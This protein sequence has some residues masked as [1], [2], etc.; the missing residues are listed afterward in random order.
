MRTVVL[1][2]F[3]LC[4]LLA[5]VY[6]E[7]QAQEVAPA[8]RAD[9]NQADAQQAGELK[10]DVQQADAQQAEE[11][12]VDTLTAEELSIQNA[13]SES[14][15]NR[16]QNFKSLSPAEQ[17]KIRQAK[18]VT[19]K[20]LPP[21]NKLIAI[22]GQLIPAT[23][24]KKNVK[25]IVKVE[26]VNKQAATNAKKSKKLEKK[27]QEQQ[28]KVTNLK[29]RIEKLKSS[30]SKSKKT[31]RKIKHLNK[32]LR[33]A[34]KKLRKCQK[35]QKKAAKKVASQK[36]FLINNTSVA[37]LQ[38]TIKKNVVEYKKKTHAL[39]KNMNKQVKVASK[40]PTNA[41]IIVAKK[42][43][44]EVLKHARNTAEIKRLLSKAEGNI[45]KLV[46]KAY[47]SEGK[48]MKKN[49]KKA[50]KTLKKA[51]KK[52]KKAVKKNKKAKRQCKCQK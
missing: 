39:V 37:Q 16:R 12:K 14:V 32:K 26:K 41:N 2:L 24:V 13:I 38:L 50:L 23:T 33:K 49:V 52:H 20:L 31:Q 43:V 10:V 45:K 28:K 17:Q 51:A 35:A 8:L 4:A 21:R 9:V 25:T 15:R 36:K 11:Q 47:R 7:E 6:T 40:K 5:F 48:F 29:N 34:N 42:S 27:A 18:A 30:N 1:V 22:N 3:A 19:K 44:K 46:K